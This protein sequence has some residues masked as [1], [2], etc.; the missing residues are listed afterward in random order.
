MIDRTAV[1]LNGVEVSNAHRTLAYLRRAHSLGLFDGGCEPRCTVNDACWQDAGSFAS[2]A[3]DPAPWYLVAEPASGEFIGFLIDRIEGLDSATSTRDLTDRINRGGVLGRQFDGPRKV[4]I[5]GTLLAS[6]GR[7]MEYGQRWMTNILLSC[8]ECTGAGSDLTFRAAC[9]PVGTSDDLRRTTSGVALVDMDAPESIHEDG[10][11]CDAYYQ[12]FSFTLGL[13][14]PDVFSLSNFGG[15]ANAA[16]ILGS[17]QACNASV[18]CCAPL[19]DVRRYQWRA[20]GGASQMG[21]D[22]IPTITFTNGSAVLHRFRVEVHKAT[23]TG[24]GTCINQTPMQAAYQCSTPITV[25]EI[26]G[27]PAGASLVLSGQTGTATAFLAGAPTIPLPGEQ[28]INP[29]RTA[30]VRGLLGL[31]GPVCVLGAPTALIAPGAGTLWSV[32]M[33]YRYRIG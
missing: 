8:D 9:A 30:G 10:P 12:T 7:G 21:G 4:R 14:S 23:G 1:Y 28:Y 25:M 32:T 16:A 17:P 26:T 22:P 20:A 18:T 5:T 13:S 3:T 27:L 29:D 2:P 6:S 33:R 11:E 24:A 19:R 31:C 15:F